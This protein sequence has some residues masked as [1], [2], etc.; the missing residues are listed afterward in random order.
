MIDKTRD[1]ELPITN[2]EHLS[3]STDLL[4]KLETE[5]KSSG[6]SF[7]NVDGM[8]NLAKGHIDANFTLFGT[9]EVEKIV[10]PDFS[11][12]AGADLGVDIAL[13]HCIAESSK[14]VAT[15]TRYV[16]ERRKF[17]LPHARGYFGVDYKNF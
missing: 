14:K 17:I 15:G 9:L 12:Y 5:S 3:G 4:N 10:K 1:P 8:A 11:I 6:S 7:F 2:K 13:H 16:L